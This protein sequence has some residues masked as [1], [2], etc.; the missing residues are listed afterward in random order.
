MSTLLA[1]KSKHCESCS[2]FYFPF[3]IDID[4]HAYHEGIDHWAQYGLQQKQHSAYWA[5]VGDDA[6]AV[7]NGG[8]CLNG[9]EE[10]RDEAVDIV[11]TRRPRLVLQMVQVTPWGEKKENV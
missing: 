8:L 6:V 2:F 5:L 7:A 3:V 4:P 9:E 10:G 1:I 11:D